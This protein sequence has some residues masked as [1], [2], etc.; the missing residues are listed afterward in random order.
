MSIYLKTEEIRAS[1]GAIVKFYIQDCK[2]KK[3]IPQEL[4]ELIKHNFLAK[5]VSYNKNDET[6]EIGI[7]I[8]KHRAEMYPTIE[9]FTFPVNSAEKWLESSFKTGKADLEFYAKMINRDIR[10]TREEVVVV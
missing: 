1:L 5:Y 4:A 2:Q 8:S 6:I 7:N 10:F 9:I 3:E